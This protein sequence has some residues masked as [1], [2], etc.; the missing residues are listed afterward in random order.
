M[1]AMWVAASCKL[2]K[3]L[4][5]VDAEC[6]LNNSRNWWTGKFEDE[7]TIAVSAV[8]FVKFCRN[9]FKR[10][11]QSSK[12]RSALFVSFHLLI[13]LTDKNKK[14]VRTS[15]LGRLIPIWR[16]K[17]GAD[18]LF[19]MISKLRRTSSN[20]CAQS[21]LHNSF[22][23]SRDLNIEVSRFEIATAVNRDI[24]SAFSSRNKAFSWELWICCALRKASWL[25]RAFARC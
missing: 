21:K 16:C 18:D 17:T 4:L 3:V 8:E 11:V 24:G 22:A 5:T 10:T 25:S 20:L 9:F 19:V 2:T 13:F 15:L 7:T 23:L 1:N 14:R 6:S 12:S